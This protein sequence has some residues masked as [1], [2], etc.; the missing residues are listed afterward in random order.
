MADNV[1]DTVVEDV[2]QNIRV[3]FPVDNPDLL[4]KVEE[5]LEVVILNAF[6][7]HGVFPTNARIR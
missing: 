4:E 2:K 5:H 3:V 7:K 6:Y 1:I